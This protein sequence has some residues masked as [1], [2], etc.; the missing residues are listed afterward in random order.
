MTMM[1]GLDLWRCEL[2]VFRKRLTPHLDCAR[3]C[4]Q[5]LTLVHQNR[6]STLASDFAVVGA[7]SPDFPQKLRMLGA[8]NWQV[9]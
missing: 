4:A 7:K 1:G 5:N 3:E 6:A 8:S 2:E 9:F